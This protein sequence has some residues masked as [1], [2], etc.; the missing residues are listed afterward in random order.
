MAAAL[1]CGV[2]PMVS[3]ADVVINEINYN[4]EPN[5]ARVEFVELHNT[6][7]G[8]VDLSGWTLDDAVS[9]TIPAGT[10]LDAGG[11]LVVA[12][13]PPSLTGSLGPYVGVLSG[14]ADQVTLRSAVGLKVDEVNY[15]SEFP[16]PI[17]A[18]GSGASMEL[19][20]P[21]LDNDLGGAWRSSLVPGKQTELVLIEE[22]SSGWRWRRGDSEASEPVGAWREGT[23]I[24]DDS[25]MD[26]QLPI[27][28]GGVNDMTFNTEVEGMQSNHTSIFARKAFEIPAGELPGR[29]KIRYAADDGVIIWING[30]EVARWQ[31]DD[32]EPTI[33][34]TA[35]G[36]KDEGEWKENVL[37]DAG[38]FFVVGTNTIALQLFNSSKGGS[39]LG[40]DLEVTRLATLDGT[41]PVP[42]PGAQNSVYS[43]SAPPYVRQVA[44]SPEQ[45]KTGTEAVVT[46]KATDPDGVGSVKLEY[47]I[48]QPGAY[49]PAYLAKTTS[50]L[51][52][53]PNDPNERNPEYFGAD[54]WMSVAMVDDGTDGD[55]TAG[56]DTYSVTLPAQVNRALVRYRIVVEDSKGAGATVPYPDDESLNFAYF[57]YDGVPDYVADTRSVNDLPH[58]YS[59]DI[60]T[61]VPVYHMLTHEDDFEQCVAYSGGNQIDRGAFD[62]RKAYNWRCTFVYNGK[63]YDNVGYRLRQRNARYSGSGKRS[64]R[65]RFSRGSYIQLHDNDGEAYSTKWRSLATTKMRSSRGTVTWGMYQSANH[66]LWNLMGVPASFTHWSH[67]RVVKSPEERPEGE[68]GQYLGDYYGLLLV[69]EEFDKRFL[70]AHNMVPGNLYKL[71]S[72]RTNGKDVQRYQAATSVDDASDFSNI[73][74]Q[75]KPQRDD[76][77]LRD[78]VDYDHWNRYHTVLEAVRSFDVGNGDTPN[79]G[80]HLKNRAYY[81]V[82]AEGLEL[83]RLR[84]LPW[85]SDTSWGPNWNGGVAWPKNAIWH[86]SRGFERPEFEREYRNTV[87]EFRDLIWTEEQIDIVL[88]KLIATI[89]PIV[90]ADRDRWVRAVS[91]PGTGR[92]NDA[93]ELVRTVDDMKE[94]AFNLDG[95]RSSWTGGTWGGGAASRESQDSGISGREGRHKYLDWLGTDEAIPETPTITYSGADGF[96]QDGLNFTSSAFAD[97]QGA[98]T[99]GAMEYRVGE[100]SDEAGVP[101]MEFKAEWESGELAAFVEK[102]DVPTVAVKVGRTYRARVRHCDADGRWSHWSEPVEFKVTAPSIGGHLEGLVISEIMY[103]PVAPTEAE[104]A[105]NDSWVGNDFDWVEL[106]NVGAVA[107]DLTDVRFTKGVE[108]DFVD[109]VRKS[110]EPG[111]RVVVAGN[112]AAFNARYGF[113]ET[114]AFVLGQFSRSLSNSGEQL[115]LSFGGGTAIRDL[116]YGDSDPWPTPPDGDGF[117][118]VLSAPDSVP[119]HALAASWRAGAVVGGTPG[120]G[121]SSGFVGDPNAD[122]DGDG[123]VALLEYGQGGSDADG[124]RAPAAQVTV[125]GNTVRF[126]VSRNAAAGD[127]TFFFEVSGDLKT[128]L[129]AEFS[130]WDGANRAIYSLPQGNTTELW[131]RSRVTLP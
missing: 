124:K 100:I 25:W 103:H 68:D 10:T 59:K 108:F 32:G 126:V 37:E 82:P 122:V 57:V 41:P 49:V 3:R 56:D 2:V 94:Y 110:I 29:L 98:E 130:G 67:F 45:P 69:M 52:R 77:W 75:L 74:R 95:K 79:N 40:V 38:S 19:I 89:G 64:F 21:S 66:I 61:S 91:T 109:G 72:G 16:W 80:E 102:A 115:K 117:S 71:I 31:V 4:G 50:V 28:F 62:A 127:V 23:F 12:E 99:F 30:H 18:G 121:E 96:P 35:S 63:V 27:G 65:Y 26:A 87:R 36:S 85:D 6:G 22:K 113:N 39:D 24:E 60:I 107:L 118:L 106:T 14:D 101:E 43:E 76:Q 34:S 123:E 83:G 54:K 81:F 53:N 7:P 5:P 9:F 15:K 17:G 93:R 55:A 11:F 90:P 46:A 84:V 104:K 73:I 33:D 105:I 58:T 128:W 48:V 111:E 20:H 47:Q 129:P 114:P 88:N 131:G 120:A 119:D 78:H 125:D 97:P 42:T 86:T 112:I 92:D 44:H 8:S 70:D 1:V 116:T 51:R 13:H